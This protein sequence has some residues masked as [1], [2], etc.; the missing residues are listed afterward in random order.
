MTTA[1]LDPTS[2]PALDFVLPADLEASQPPEAVTGDRSAVR[3]LVSPGAG[4]PVDTTFGALP[5]WLRPGDLVVVN[6]SATVP[7]SLEG[8]FPDGG[9]VEV[10][11]STE[12]PGDLWLVELRRPAEPASAPFLGEPPAREIAVPDGGRVELL[13]HQPGS[14]RLWLAHV[15][16]PLPVLDYLALHGAPIRYRHVPEPWPLAAYQ[17]VYA[18]EPGSAEMPSAGRAFTPEL[19]T[20]LVARG[21]GVSPV[22]LHTGVSSPEAHEPPFPE[23][24][25]VP[26]VTAARVNATHAEGGRVVAIGTTVVRALET[27]TDE[28][29]VAHPGSGWTDTV[30]TPERGVRAVDGLLTGW[31]EPQAS[32]LLMLEAI[33]GRPILEAAYGA[34]LALQY[35]WHE[36]G[37]LHL[38]LP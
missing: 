13:A 8:R 20:E 17:T 7:A 4:D 34:A 32:H 18:V 37:D 12:V 30:I 23:R 6:T 2:H 9:E 27:V 33:A 14:E 26:R 15:E 5:D 3:M 28:V 19:L 1:L 29:G 36:F 11:L 21:V 35:R 31:H 10:H 22:V 16:L 25:L 24:Y 38:I